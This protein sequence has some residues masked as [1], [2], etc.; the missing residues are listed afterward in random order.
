[1]NGHGTSANST[2]YDVHSPP[3]SDTVP[4]RGHGLGTSPWQIGSQAA[5]RRR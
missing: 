5:S 3:G 1:M 4:R 2:H